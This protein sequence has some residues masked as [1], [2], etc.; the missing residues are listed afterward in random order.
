MSFFLKHIKFACVKLAVIDMTYLNHLG[1]RFITPPPQK[2]GGGWG[3]SQLSSIVAAAF[4]HQKESYKYETHEFPKYS[5]N[6]TKI[7]IQFLLLMYN[8]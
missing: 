5:K 1:K 6:D 4:H 7:L 8:C 3:V 2:K